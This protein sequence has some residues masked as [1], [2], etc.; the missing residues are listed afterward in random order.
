MA[1]KDSKISYDVNLHHCSLRLLATL[2]ISI[3]FLLVTRLSFEYRVADG[4]QSSVLAIAITR[5]PPC[6]SNYVSLSSSF[7]SIVK[8]LT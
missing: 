7:P 3:I 6:S 8:D 5:N 2:V 4:F 1:Y